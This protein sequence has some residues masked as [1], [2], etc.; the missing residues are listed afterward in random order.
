MKSD[1]KQVFADIVCFDLPFRKEE[2][3]FK[4][5][6]IMSSKVC[7]RFLYSILTLATQ[8][9]MFSLITK[10]KKACR[11]EIAGTDDK[12][13]KKKEDRKMTRKS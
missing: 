6:K 11:L 12:L 9:A 7:Q 8:W 13:G 5:G 10:P 1:K 2:G 3:K 4:Q